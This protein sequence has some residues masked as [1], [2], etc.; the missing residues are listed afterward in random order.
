[1]GNL[2]RESTVDEYELD[3][4]GN[5]VPRKRSRNGRRSAGKNRQRSREPSSLSL[6][7]ER[8]LDGD[9]GFSATSKASADS[10]LGGD[11]HDAD[12]LAT[13]GIITEYSNADE[14][15]RVE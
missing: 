10:G 7:D 15:K 9:R 8:S 1:M 5:K 4:Q 11:G 3:E 2:S 13:L 6:D 14:V 12:E